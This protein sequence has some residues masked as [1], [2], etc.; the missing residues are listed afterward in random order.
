MTPLSNHVSILVSDQNLSRAAWGADCHNT[1][2][3]YA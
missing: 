1:T 3:I 2:V